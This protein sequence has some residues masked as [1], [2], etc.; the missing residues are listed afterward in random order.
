MSSPK[1]FFSAAKERIYWQGTVGQGK[2]DPP[3]LMKKDLALRDAPEIRDNVDS[4][5]LLC[6]MPATGARRDKFLEASTEFGLTSLASEI[7]KDPANTASIKFTRPLHTDSELTMELHDD[8][9]Y[10]LYLSWGIT[11]DSAAI[12]TKD[13]VRGDTI[14]GVDI[15]GQAIALPEL[16]EFHVLPAPP[17]RCSSASF[18]SSALLVAATAM[19]IANLF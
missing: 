1:A 16:V 11:Q 2:F 8:A 10:M 17:Q 14:A 7:K 9:S 6:S 3:L 15:D 4:Y 12:G 18:I 5:W 19:G 13:D